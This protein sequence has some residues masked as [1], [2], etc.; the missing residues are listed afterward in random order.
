MYIGFLG[1]LVGLTEMP[2]QL[3]IS[4]AVSLTLALGLPSLNLHVSRH[5]GPSSGP[6]LITLHSP[7]P[8]GNWTLNFGE[9]F[10]T[11]AR[12]HLV[13]SRSISLLSRLN[14]KLKKCAK[15]VPRRIQEFSKGSQD[16]GN[17]TWRHVCMRGL[18]FIF[19]LDFLYG[20][21]VKLPWYLST[22]RHSEFKKVKSHNDRR[23]EFCT[24]L[25]YLPGYWKWYGKDCCVVMHHCHA[26]VVEF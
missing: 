22:K 23:T 1:L 5:C 13:S 3:E 20:Y 17:R 14:G 9:R 11:E 6:L 16:V 12:D 19:A 26:V 4:H 15:E 24:S 2:S 10:Q 25:S 8:F 18:I 21:W 7:H